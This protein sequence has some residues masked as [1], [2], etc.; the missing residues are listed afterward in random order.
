M[1]ERLNIYVAG[2]I[3]GTDDFRER[4]AK[5]CQEVSLLGYQPVCPLDLPKEFEDD[6]RA[7]I[8][9]ACMRVDIP[10]LINCHGIFLMAG[11]ENSRGARLEKLIADG[12]GLILLFQEEENANGR[13]A[14]GSSGVCP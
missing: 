8:W 14:T 9:L 7:E 3:S 2:P 11:W 10:A 4:F 13:R 6:G 12:L 5:A 1:P